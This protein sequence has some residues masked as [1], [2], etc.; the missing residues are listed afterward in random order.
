[1]GQSV[2]LYFSSTGH[3]QAIAERIAIAT[4]SQLVAI[5]AQVHD[6]PT[7]DWR[8]QQNQEY[9]RTHVERVRPA[10]QAIDPAPIKAATTIYLGFPIWW[11]T[12]PQEIETFL[13]SIDLVGKD[14]HPFC[15][16]GETSI[17]EAVKQLRDGYPAIRW[18]SGRRFASSLTNQEIEDWAEE[19]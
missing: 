9:H 12:V 1:M 2:V 19:D 8:D 15:T 18:H 11:A 5:H 3:T 4:G 13:D 10:I 6:T 17:F 16:S 14:V 7:E